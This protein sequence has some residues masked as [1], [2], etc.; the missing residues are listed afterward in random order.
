MSFGDPK[1]NIQLPNLPAPEHLVS[2]LIGQGPPNANPGM[3]GVQPKSD[4]NPAGEMDGVW[5][6]TMTADQAKFI[7]LAR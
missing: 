2:D 5:I 6:G 4:N 1:T 7:G 3:K